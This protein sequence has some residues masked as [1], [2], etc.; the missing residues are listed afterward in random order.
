MNHLFNVECYHYRY[1]RKLNTNKLEFTSL[2]TIFIHL[3]PLADQKDLIEGGLSQPHSA[4]CRVTEDVIEGDKLTIEGE[5][6]FIRGVKEYNI[7]NYPHKQ[8]I[9]EKPQAGEG[10]GSSGS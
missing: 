10:G 9:L 3:Q 5:T 8:L 2:G 6:Y 1:T 4:W 7:S